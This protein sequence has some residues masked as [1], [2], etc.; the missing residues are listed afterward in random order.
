MREK[1]KN[2]MDQKGIVT[3]RLIELLKIFTENCMWN[4]D[5]EKNTIQLIQILKTISK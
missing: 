4:F 2:G 1:I 5:Y 3:L